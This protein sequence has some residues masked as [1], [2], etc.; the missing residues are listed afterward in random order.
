MRMSGKLWHRLRSWIDVARD[1]V[2]TLARRDGPNPIAAWRQLKLGR[3]VH[4]V[5]RG[6]DPVVVELQLRTDGC[7]LLI[8]V[9]HRCRR[10]RHRLTA[11]AAHVVDERWVVEDE[12]VLRT[13]AHGP[14]ELRSRGVGAALLALGARCECCRPVCGREVELVVAMARSRYVVPAVMPDILMR[15]RQRGVPQHCGDV[16][17]VKHAVRGQGDAG[18]AER[19]REQ[20]QRADDIVRHDASGNGPGPAS[21]AGHAD[22][23]LVRLALGALEPLARRERG[24]PAVV[25]ALLRVRSII[26]EEKDQRI[27][28]DV[29]SIQRRENPPDGPVHLFEIVSK[30][31]PLR[32]VHKCWGREERRVH[33]HERHV[34]EEWLLALRVAIDE[35]HG[36]L[37]EHGCEV[38]VDGWLLDNRI[39][40]HEDAV[41]FALIRLVRVA[42]WHVGEWDPEV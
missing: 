19:R 25:P 7:D 30:A 24:A 17:A 21:E 38:G 11:V 23:T 36:V 27:V 14:S 8:V 37:G 5:G 9:G 39:I 40:G 2:V 41:L 32:D 22:A 15:R 18:N 1:V 20:I 10:Q 16:Q 33:V 34:E 35:V 12:V 3:G 26:A 28:G 13:V 31:T 29:V 4:L 6:G 42:V